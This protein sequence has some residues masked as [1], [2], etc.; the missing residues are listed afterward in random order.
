MSVDHFYLNDIWAL[1][2]LL[3]R[4]I[5]LAGPDHA[6]RIPPMNPM[7]ADVTATIGFLQAYPFMDFH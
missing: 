1:F 3:E 6:S 7:M 2:F 5:L 4:Y